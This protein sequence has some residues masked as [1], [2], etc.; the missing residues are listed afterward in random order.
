MP[1]VPELSLENRAVRVYRPDWPST[2]SPFAFWNFFTAETVAESY[3]PVM[4]VL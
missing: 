3:L 4:L 2:V 1:L